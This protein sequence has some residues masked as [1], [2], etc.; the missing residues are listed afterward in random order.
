[1][2]WSYIIFIT[3]LMMDSLDYVLLAATL[4]VITGVMVLYSIRALYLSR[5]REHSP[6]MVKILVVAYLIAAVIVVIKIRNSMDELSGSN[7]GIL[8]F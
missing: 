2:I 3:S 8:P 1:M 7:P 6:M 5:S 4:W